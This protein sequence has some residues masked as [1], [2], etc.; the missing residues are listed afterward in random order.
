MPG[1]QLV[2]R[3]PLWQPGSPSPWADLA[4]GQRTGLDLARVR[5]MLDG[6]DRVPGGEDE[7][8][9]PSAA[10][11]VALFDEDGEAH[12]VLTRRAATMRSHKHQ[13][14][15][16]GGRLDPGERLDQA[17]LR[18]AEEEVG[19]DPAAVEL[20]G[21][22]PRFEAFAGLSSITPFV[23]ALPA[24]PDL[25]PNPAEVE[26]AFTV[27]LTQLVAP[28]VHWEERWPLPGGELYPIHFF[29]LSLDLVW[30]AT[31][32]ILVSFLTALLEL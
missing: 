5:R 12:V 31:A 13:V 28:G 6:G 10:V 29:D 20:L 2:P 30:G 7:G 4:P 22:L 3:P 1:P 11:L 23:G 27:P 16:P 8:L 25:R 19:L 26:R 9:G 14:S 32:R 21:R 18:E 24:R 15:F 17:A